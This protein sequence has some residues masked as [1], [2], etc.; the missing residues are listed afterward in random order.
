M[1]TA[2]MARKKE[3]KPVPTTEV[4]PKAVRLDLDPKLHGQLRIE[5]AKLGKPMAVIVRDLVVKFL[6]ERTKKGGGK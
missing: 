3:V 1:E 2:V 4:V 6:E 5:A